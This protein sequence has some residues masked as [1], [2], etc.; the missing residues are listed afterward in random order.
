VSL[1]GFPVLQRDSLLPQD[2][3]R[4]LCQRDFLLDFLRASAWMHGVGGLIARQLPNLPRS[5]PG[6]DYKNYYR[7]AGDVSGTR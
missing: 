7:T 3:G 5:L 2:C 6:A 4:F 1:A